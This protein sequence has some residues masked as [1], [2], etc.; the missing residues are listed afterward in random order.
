MGGNF[1]LQS[2][3]IV[4]G[5]FTPELHHLA[6]ADKIKVSHTGYLSIVIFQTKYGISIFLIAEY[7]MLHISCNNFHC[8]SF[9]TAGQG[10]AL[11]FT[12]LS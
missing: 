10:C 2:I 5:I 3:Y 12:P 9:L 8:Q 7:N 1:Q 6:F 11:L 4:I